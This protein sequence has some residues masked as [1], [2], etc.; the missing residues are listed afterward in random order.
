MS[1][2]ENLVTD[3]PPSMRLF[4]IQDVARILGIREESVR[5]L[6]HE[7][8]LRASRVGVLLRVPQS[9][10]ER[11][12]EEN[13]STGPDSRRNGWRGKTKRRRRSEEP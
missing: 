5:R 6:V 11:Y 13:V 12:L 4:S 7:G 8:R 3:L 9:A 10:L 1:D 2:T